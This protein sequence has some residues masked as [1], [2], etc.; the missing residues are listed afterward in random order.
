MKKHYVMNPLEAARE[1]HRRNSSWRPRQRR[2]FLA[3]M[4]TAT[5]SWLVGCGGGDD[6]HRSPDLEA[7]YEA[8]AEGMSYA[9]VRGIVGSDP[10]SQVADGD[11]VQ[12]Y[13][14]ESGEGTYLY[15]SLLVRIHE[16]D[17]VTGKTVTGPNGNMTETYGSK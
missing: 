13:R 12:L 17:G 2:L 5:G 6:D 15:T 11:K 4:V 14:W 7:A 16:R 10:L 9:H 1:S 3:A 8:I